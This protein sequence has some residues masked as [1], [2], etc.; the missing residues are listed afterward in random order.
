M[1]SRFWRSHLPLHHSLDLGTSLD[2]IHVCY[3]IG[4]TNISLWVADQSNWGLTFWGKIDLYL[5]AVWHETNFLHAHRLAF[6]LFHLRVSRIDFSQLNGINCKGIQW[7]D[8][9]VS[10]RFLISALFWA[11]NC[12]CTCLSRVS[13]TAETKG[14]SV[15]Q[16]RKIQ[17]VWGWCYHCGVVRW[18]L[19]REVQEHLDHWRTQWYVQS[20]LSCQDGQCDSSSFA[21]FFPPLHRSCR[22]EGLIL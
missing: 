4:P 10:L 9:T 16:F 2:L 15:S 1:G 19:L 8:D 5:E 14:V 22:Q 20:L 12:V 18:E 21:Y 17:Q 6:P 3:T 7:W 13:E 11:W